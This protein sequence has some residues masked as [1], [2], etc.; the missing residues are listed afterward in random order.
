MPACMKPNNKRKI[1]GLCG[2]SG[3]GKSTLSALLQEKGAEIL[4]ADRIARSFTEPGSSALPQLRKAFGDGVF[5]PDQTLNRQALAALVFSNP[6][7]LK[8]L[9]ALIHPK[10]TEEIKSRLQTSR[11]N[12]IIIDAPLLQQ[13]GLDRLCDLT[14]CVTA[15]KELRIERIMRRDHISYEAAAAR[16][17][18]QPSEKEYQQGA[19]LVVCNDGSCPPEALIQI[20]LR[21]DKL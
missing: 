20:I 13:A 10:V 19:D 2:G 4:D 12:I 6:E 3:S 5:Y 21:S 18:A 7:Q 11:A 8:Q 16:I 14:V 15:P 1:I 9:N 17:D